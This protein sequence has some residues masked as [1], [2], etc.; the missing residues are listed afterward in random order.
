[1]KKNNVTYLSDLDDL[2]DL[3]SVPT[4]KPQDFNT[5]MIQESFEREQAMNPLK[6]KMRKD[7][8]Y[9]QA[10]NGGDYTTMN[11]VPQDTYH[12][13]QNYQMQG[14]N[15]EY[16]M[17][18]KSY[19][20]GPDFPPFLTENYNQLSCVDVANHLNS[21]PVCS[22]LYNDDYKSSYMI[23]IGLLIVA[24]IILVKKLLDDKL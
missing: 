15:M 7:S 18:P 13:T 16:R 21:C 12:H 17:G 23:I 14:D 6:Q 3:D 1:M 8:N 22:K 11:V 24:V 10:L 5:K 9:K 20:Y 19:G 4:N 2:I